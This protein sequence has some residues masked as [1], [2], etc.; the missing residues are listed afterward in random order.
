MFA[1]SRSLCL[2]KAFSEAECRALSAELQEA[3]DTVW[4]CVCNDD[5]DAA[6]EGFEGL[7]ALARAT[8]TVRRVRDL[9]GGS[10]EP[11]L[12]LTTA[13]FLLEALG[14]LSPQAEESMF[15]VTG[16]RL[17]NVHTLDRIIRFE[18]ER[19]TLT[20]VVGE[21][22]SAHEA[23]IRLHKEDLMLHAAFHIHPGSG[24]RS[25]QPSSTDRGYQASL[26]EAG[27]KTVGLIFTRDGY[28][29]AFSSEMDFEIEVT[30]RRAERLGRDLFRLDVVGSN[31]NGASPEDS[32]R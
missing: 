17:A 11:P 18:L 16:A 21:H 4:S 7:L 13:S 20:E 28:V 15:F 29:R 10:E 19:S 23:L 3:R 31:R 22:R 8:R 30:G 9:L 14:V 27:Y 5:L 32:S 26:E 24:A 6:R 1:K 2:A 12:F 25:T